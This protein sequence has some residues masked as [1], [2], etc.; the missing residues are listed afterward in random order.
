MILSGE[1][2]S[3]TWV[4]PECEQTP[5]VLPDRRRCP[6]RDLSDTP[7]EHQDYFVLCEPSHAGFETSLVVS[8]ATANK[9]VS[10]DDII[11][12]FGN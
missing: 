10:K 4:N 5:P 7:S 9:K 6:C 3:H 11:I 8:R 2:K 1:K 12:F